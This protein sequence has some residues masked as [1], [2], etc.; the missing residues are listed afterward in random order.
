MLLATV[1][2]AVTGCAG[3]FGQAD[4]KSDFTV[5]EIAGRPGPTLYYVGRSFEGLPLTAI[6]G[7]RTYPSFIYGDCEIADQGWFED[8]GCAP[9]LSIQYESTSSYEAKLARLDPS[10]SCTRMTVRGV[11]AAVLA[12]GLRVFTGETAVTIHANERGLARRAA[13]ALRPVGEGA[14][15]GHELPQPPASIRRALQ[16]C[17]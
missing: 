4:P 1:A 10:V 15:P 8:G 11:P 17:R 2:L 5:E 7:S 9:P 14:S 3:P 13:E 12:G 16:A 6:V